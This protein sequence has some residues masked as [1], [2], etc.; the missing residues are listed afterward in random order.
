M[1]EHA[2]RSIDPSPRIPNGRRGSWRRKECVSVRPPACLGQNLVWVDFRVQGGGSAGFS[3]T[4]RHHI[5]KRKAIPMLKLRAILAVLVLAPWVFLAGLASPASA[6]VY[7]NCTPTHAATQSGGPGFYTVDYIGNFSCTSGIAYARIRVRLETPYGA[8]TEGQDT[9]T[10]A[11]CQSLP[12]P[13]AV[14]STNTAPIY[15]SHVTEYWGVFGLP[16]PYRWTHTGPNC[17]GQGS[18]V[19]YCHL[20]GMYTVSPTVP[21]NS[22]GITCSAIS[23]CVP[24]PDVTLVGVTTPDP[25]DS[26]LPT[27]FGPPPAWQGP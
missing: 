5:A 19:A 22:T 14:A 26:S 27:D 4:A 12:F 13:G 17:T 10:C 11:L 6:A 15:S 16:R 24:T 8:Q 20:A 23:E 25:L 7:L 21:T 9:K 3:E 1:C 18:R 2:G